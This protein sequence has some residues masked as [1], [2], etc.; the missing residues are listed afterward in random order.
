MV[1][2]RELIN[3][4][5]E[6]FLEGATPSALIN[7]VRQR[8]P[9]RPPGFEQMDI[10]EEAF[11]IPLVAQFGLSKAGPITEDHGRVLNKVL[12]PE[13][14]LHSLEWNETGDA[15]FTGAKISDPAEIRDR[16]DR[17]TYPGLSETTWNNLSTDERDALLGQL[18]H[19]EVMSQRTEVLARLCERLQRRIDKLEAE[20]TTV[21][22]RSVVESPDNRA[23]VCSVH[24]D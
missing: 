23:I 3:E 15:W 1:D 6:K 12:L 16:L 13:M 4:L 2:R 14:L 21:V 24:Y 17:E 7:L 8:V 22:E 10:I 9:Y 18:A 5:R 20:W 19:G 11:F